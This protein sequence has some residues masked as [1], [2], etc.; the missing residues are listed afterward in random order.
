MDVPSSVQWSH[1]NPTPIYQRISALVLFL[2]LFNAPFRLSE[3]ILSYHYNIFECRKAGNKGQ[4]L[5]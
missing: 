1:N 3:R 4:A 2:F 5:P